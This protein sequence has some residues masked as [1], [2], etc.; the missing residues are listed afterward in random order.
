MAATTTEREETENAD[1]GHRS[2]ATS[3][4]QPNFSLPKQIIY[5]DRNNTPDIWGDIKRTVDESSYVA[6][7]RSKD[8]RTVVLLPKQEAFD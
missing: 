3:T 2:N 1:P 5:L 8:Y 6:P 4:N 7:G